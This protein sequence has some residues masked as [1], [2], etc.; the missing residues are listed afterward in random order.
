MNMSRIDIMN[1][2]GVLQLGLQ[3]NFWIAMTICNWCCIFTPMSVIG[4]VAWGAKYA[5]RHIYDLI[6]MQLIA[7]QLQQFFFNYYAIPLWLQ[8]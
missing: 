6:L 3:L 4:Q 2:R 7:I 8:P 1:I 5:T